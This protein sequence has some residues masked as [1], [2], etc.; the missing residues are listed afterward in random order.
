MI[1]SKRR[2]AFDPARLLIIGDIML[3]RFCYGSVSRISPE[4]PVPVVR[5]D[6]VTAMLGGAG[7]VLANIRALDCAGGLI[8]VV[9]DD[10]SGRECA[11]M[12]AELGVDPSLL[13]V[14]PGRTTTVKT[15]F[16]SGS[17]HLLRCDEEDPLP[18]SASVEQDLIARFDASISDYDA[19]AISDYAKGVLSDRVLAYVIATCRTRGVPVIVDPKR[20]DLTAY[21]GATVIK[22]NRS[23]LAAFTRMACTDIESSKIAA[24]RAMDATGAAVLLTLSEHGMALFR[25]GQPMHHFH[26]TATE[27][28]DVSGAGDTALAVFCVALAS[29]YSMEEA[30]MLANAG[31]GAVVRKLGTATLTRM[32]LCEAVAAL[33]PRPFRAIATREQAAA[34]VAF[35]KNEGLR[36]GFTNGCFDIVHAGHIALLREARARCDRLVVGLNSDASVT[37]LKGP[38]RP[39]QSQDSRSEVLAALEA[40]DLVVVFGEDTPAE[41]I[42]LLLPTDLI[43]GADYTEENVVGAKE[44]K[45][46][47]GRVHLIELVPGCST[48]RAVERIKLGLFDG[49]ANPKHDETL[50]AE[51]M[52][53][54]RRL[55]RQPT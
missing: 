21:A 2:I 29:N 6:R 4:A 11:N 12:I 10:E 17:Q 3:D 16:I 50:P 53:T 54:N 47:G 20:A 35:W 18:F 31:A 26:A 27:V 49:Q 42:S 1:E 37:R 40:V 55:S 15:R 24:K 44:V 38:A 14:A 43:K 7:N 52:Q 5:A 46:A 9:G 34:Q 39:V 41:L 33:D 22:P 19:V 36:V 45:A 48:T 30:A 23:E 25:P 13:V 28:Y 32:E 51:A 8:S